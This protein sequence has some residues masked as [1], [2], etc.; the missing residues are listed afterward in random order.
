MISD[1]QI[2]NQLLRRI[3]RIRADKLR[4]LDDYAAK[5]EENFNNK[6]KIL[7][8]AGAWE[9]IDDDLFNDF[10]DRLI[11]RRQRNKRRIDE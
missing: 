11:T 4:Q 2:R 5:L 10:T 7:S 9:N 3:H 6:D 1:T 8:F